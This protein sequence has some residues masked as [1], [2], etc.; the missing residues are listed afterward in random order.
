MPTITY[1]SQR[2]ESRD[3]TVPPGTT[4]MQ[5]AIKNGVEG[6]L[7]ECGGEC[8]CATCHVYVDSQFLPLLDPIGENEEAMLDST[9]A[10]RRPNS[11]LG[12]QVPITDAL[13][14]IVVTTPE[15]Q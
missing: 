13:D 10:E 3:V 1:I 15:R 14:G 4:I 8:M 6:I 7:A 2:G 11:R 9:A 12:C 5:G